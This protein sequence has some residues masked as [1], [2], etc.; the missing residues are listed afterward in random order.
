[1]KWTNLHPQSMG[2]TQCTV[3]TRERKGRGRN[4]ALAAEYRH[5]SHGA[6]L[7]QVA[8]CLPRRR[9][10]SKRFTQGT[11]GTKSSL[12]HAHDQV[13]A[14]LVLDNTFTNRVNNKLQ[15]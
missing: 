14:R 13:R 5:W 3:D 12:Y 7:F 9:L 10:L 2:R 11:A 8:P 4:E 15:S 6:Q 1:M